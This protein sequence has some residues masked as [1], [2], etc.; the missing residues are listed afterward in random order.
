MAFGWNTL[1][2]S[3]QSI[4]VADV[5][6]RTLSTSQ[7]VAEVDEPVEPGDS[8]AGEGGGAEGDEE[9]GAG[10]GG[11]G[12]VAVRCGDGPGDAAD[13]H[14]EDGGD[15][16]ERQEG[17]DHVVEGGVVAEGAEVGVDVHGYQLPTGR[18]R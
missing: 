11:G 17:A 16:D 4:D 9:S 1:W 10:F 6:V 2:S 15:E 8:G 3:R 7:L 14:G 18:V 12:V 5:L 13:E